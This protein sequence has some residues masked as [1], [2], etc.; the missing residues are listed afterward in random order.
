MAV[1]LLVA[2]VTLL[3]TAF[4]LLWLLAPRLRVWMEAP[5]HRFLEIQ[6]RFPDI[7]RGDK[8]SSPR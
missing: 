7:V 2:A 8:P 4:L 5:K 1:N 6:R 3:M